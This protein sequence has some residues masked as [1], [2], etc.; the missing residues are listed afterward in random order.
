MKFSPNAKW[1]VSIDSNGVNDIRY[2]TLTIPLNVELLT[3][4]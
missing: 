2:S 3:W 1:T 4:W